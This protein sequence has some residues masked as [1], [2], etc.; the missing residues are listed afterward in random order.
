MAECTDVDSTVSLKGDV[1]RQLL[2]AV[3]NS[4]L[5]LAGGRSSGT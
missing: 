4:K 1:S 5:V 3:G 2:D